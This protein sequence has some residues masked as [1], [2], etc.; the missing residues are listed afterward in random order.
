L[1]YNWKEPTNP[2]CGLIEYLWKVDDV[3]RGDEV[4]GKTKWG[5]RN[6]KASSSR[7]TKHSNVPYL[8]EVLIEWC[9]MKKLLADF[10]TK[11]LL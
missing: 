7:R 1:T 9:S 3:M 4:C 8:G 11:P 10:M 2:C 6:G 5:G